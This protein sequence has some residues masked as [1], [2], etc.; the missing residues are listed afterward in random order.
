MSAPK[1]P[2]SRTVP[3]SFRID[4]SASIAVEEEAASQNVSSNTLVNQILKQFSEFDRFAK[5]INTVKLSSSVFR[6]LLSEVD[7]EKV[8]E[9]A[10]SAGSSIPQ[11]FATTKSGKV[12]VESL[13]DHIRC[14]AAYAHLCEFSETV[15]H[16]RLLTL[17]HDFGLNWS[18]FLVHYVNAMFEQ[19]GFSPKVEM[20]DRSVTFTLLSK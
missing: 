19:I 5:R 18:I 6:D 3:K 9:I 17:V 20:S 16:D 7:S 13:V 11:A 2:R 10:K 1:K 12:D 14:L 15:D 4:E 8:I